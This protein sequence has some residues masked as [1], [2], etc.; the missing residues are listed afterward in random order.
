MSLRGVF[1]FDHWWKEQEAK[2]WLGGGL[3]RHPANLGCPTID[4]EPRD[5]PSKRYRA[6][7]VGWQW[8][9][10]ELKAEREEG[11]RQKDAWRRKDGG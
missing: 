5:H 7:E 3:G 2:A 9:W 11:G 10:P 1:G 4:R 6:N 8:G